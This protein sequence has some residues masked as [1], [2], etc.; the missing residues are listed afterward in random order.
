LSELAE[1][2]R[3]T[4]PE[5]INISESRTDAPPCSPRMESQQRVTSSCVAYIRAI[6][7]RIA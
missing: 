1:D 3:D 2:Y 4:S 6:G 5:I 7:A